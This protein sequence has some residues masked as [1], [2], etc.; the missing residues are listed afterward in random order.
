MV[1]SMQR[2]PSGFSSLNSIYS[3]T[4][5]FLLF[6][7]TNCTD[8]REK[9]LHSDGNVERSSVRLIVNQTVDMQQHMTD[10]T[11]QYFIFTDTLFGSVTEPQPADRKSVVLFLSSSHWLW[12]HAEQRNGSS[13]AE[14]SF[15]QALRLFVWK[16][17]N[18]SEKHW[19]DGTELVTL[20]SNIMEE[21]LVPSAG[22]WMLL[23][24][25]ERLS[26]YELLASCF[27]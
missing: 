5:F 23:V 21:E 16:Y 19:L 24:S 25:V 22:H 9:S 4:F 3:S 14:K 17:H 6:P 12:K 1:Q 11:R 8:G 20:V 2:P 15:F 10:M 18:F 27:L 7:V 26:R 13:S